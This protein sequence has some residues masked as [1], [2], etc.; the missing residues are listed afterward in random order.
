[1]PKSE[2]DDFLSQVGGD[3]TP[4]SDPFIVDNQDPL[5]T[6][7][8]TD[9]KLETTEDDG[10]TVKSTEEKPLP[11][12]RDPKVQR[13]IEKEISKR[14]GTAKPTQTEAPQAGNEDELTD[15]LTEIIG[16][17]TPDKIKA[18]KRFRDQLGRL[19]ERGAERAMQQLKEQS[20]AE[21]A[22]EEEA[23]GQLV[24]AFDEIETEFGVDLT[25]TA[26]LAT[27]DRND[28]VEFLKRVS[29]KDTN[30][31][32]IQ[33]PDIKETFKLFQTT[34]KPAENKRAKEVSS[35]SMARSSDAAS[36]PQGGK[37]WKDIDRIFNKIGS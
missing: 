3:K 16:N 34:R 17:D 8:P 21:Q 33:Y 6:N 7:K 29:T 2:V 25:S 9:E 5:G 23:Y 26:T 18:V 36:T 28:F 32:I 12:H 19:E 27:K 1:M 30:G 13:Y 4:E 22:A 10:G 11:Y 35:R 37:T 15:I 24:D 20:D 14:I 31:D